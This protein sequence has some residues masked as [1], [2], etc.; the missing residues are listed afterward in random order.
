MSRRVKKKTTKKK[1]P[2]KKQ[3]EILPSEESSTSDGGLYD[4]LLPSQK[5]KTN[6][7]T[8]DSGGY[9]MVVVAVIALLLV[10]GLISG[11]FTGDLDLGNGNNGENGDANNGGIIDISDVCLKEHNLDT[12]TRYS[13]WLNLVPLGES[14]FVVIPTDI[15][16]QLSGDTLICM[17]GM[18]TH[19]TP[20]LVYIEY[21]ERYV[22]SPPTLGDFFAIWDK[23][24]SSTQ[25]LGQT[26]TVLSWIDEEPLSG[27]P[28]SYIPRQ[29]GM[30]VVRIQIIAV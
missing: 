4:H 9:N 13:F 16:V 24:L 17:Q 11:V 5:A 14:E 2:S 7:V 27:D 30:E 18:H 28:S 12:Q 22:G 6:A 1:L 26:G 10:I 15:G 8:P 20:N 19:N 25:L 23:P 3:S 21:D 29:D